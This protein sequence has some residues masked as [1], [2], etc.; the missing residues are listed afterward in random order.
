MSR[1][2]LHSAQ[3]ETNESVAHSIR[4]MTI[5][6]KGHS[7]VGGTCRRSAEVRRG[8]I[9]TPRVALLVTISCETG[10]EKAAVERMI[11]DQQ[12]VVKICVRAH[13]VPEARRSSVPEDIGRHYW[14]FGL[15][16]EVRFVTSLMINE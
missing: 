11:T 8:G 9:S 1:S 13:S 2:D 16:F 7:I 5:C 14:L 4:R 10:N 3:T 6:V 12:L 15:S